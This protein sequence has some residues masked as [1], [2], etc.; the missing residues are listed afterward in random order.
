VSFARQESILSVVACFAH[1]LALSVHL[2]KAAQASPL[3]LGAG[4]LV[5]R[6]NKIKIM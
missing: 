3:L 1:E 4:D 5:I 6:K 2:G